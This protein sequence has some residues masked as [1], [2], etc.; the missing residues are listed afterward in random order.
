MEDGVS[1]YTVD[2]VLVS[3]GSRK[4]HASVLS[5][6]GVAKISEAME[7]MLVSNM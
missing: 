1:T 6:S 5:Y 2:E 7:T 3:M 4:I